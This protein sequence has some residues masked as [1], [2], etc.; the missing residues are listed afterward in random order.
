MKNGKYV[1]N[2]KHVC[3]EAPGCASPCVLFIVK[4]FHNRTKGR[5]HGT[6]KKKKEE[7]NITKKEE[8]CDGVPVV[9]HPGIFCGCYINWKC[10]AKI[11]FHTE[12]I[13]D[14]SV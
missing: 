13:C 5:G 7:K 3:F 12:I 6:N 9:A 14:V 2:Y 1:L 8:D 4:C 11:M 10:Y